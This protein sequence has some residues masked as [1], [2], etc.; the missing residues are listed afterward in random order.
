MGDD[1]RISLSPDPANLGLEN[2]QNLLKTSENEKE[3]STL[4]PRSA[5]FVT[6]EN[7]SEKVQLHNNMNTELSQFFQSLGGK[8]TPKNGHCCRS[9]EIHPI[10]GVRYECKSCPGFSLCRIC[11][12]KGEHQEHEMTQI[13]T[14]DMPRTV[15]PPDDFTILGRTNVDLPISKWNVL[16]KLQSFVR[17]D[18]HGEIED[19]LKGYVMNIEGEYNVLGVD[20]NGLLKAKY[21]IA[22]HISV[23]TNE[24]HKKRSEIH[25]MSKNLDR[26]NEIAWLKVTALQIAVIAK[27]SNSIRAILNHLFKTDEKLSGEEIMNNVIDALAE[28][29][30]IEFSNKNQYYLKKDISLVGMNVF[31]LAAKYYPPAI[32]MMHQIARNGL[33][34]IIARKKMPETKVNMYEIKNSG[35]DPRKMTKMVG[36]KTDPIS[37]KQDHFSNVDGSQNTQN[38]VFNEDE[39]FQI[40]E[41]SKLITK[42]D[43]DHL[44]PFFV[45]KFQDNDRYKECLIKLQLLLGRQNCLKETPL[46]VAVQGYRNDQLP[47]IK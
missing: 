12:E 33:W 5:K 16:L 32:E 9:C 21:N 46:H 19:L 36:R 41:V 10:P 24:N 17:K 15:E 3:I 38:D 20:L 30:E 13:T 22:I 18:M 2:K 11:K 39:H 44:D 42:E 23:K 7:L 6:P 40:Q 1:V 43:F 45:L 14:I 29:V 35:S 27:S 28:K 34:K 25:K 8:P 47:A 4:S 26:K 37:T 31:H